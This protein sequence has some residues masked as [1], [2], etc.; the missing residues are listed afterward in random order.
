MS[1]TTSILGIN[2][3]ADNQASWEATHNDAIEQLARATNDT[4]AVTLTANAATVSADDFNANLELSV[5][6]ATGSATLTVPQTKRLFVVR[7]TGS[8]HTLQVKMPTGTSI[9]MDASSIALIISDASNLTAVIGTGLAGGG[10]SV[11]Y[12]GL[13]AELQNAPI[14]FPF[15]GKPN[16][17]QVFHVPLTQAYTLPANFASSLGYPGTV[18]TS[19]ATFAFGYVRSGTYHAVGTLKFLAAASSLTL[20]TQ[21]AVNL[22]STDIIRLTAPSPQDATLADCGITVMLQKV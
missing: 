10:G 4:L 18:A 8:T 17:G 16:D 2:E 12:S 9:T 22:L 14:S 3:I 19:D 20:S 1:G 21:A 5:S 13:P 7:N 11:G 6:G 15:G